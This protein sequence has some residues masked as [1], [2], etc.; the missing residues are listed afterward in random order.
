MT[1]NDVKPFGM[2][3]EN[4]NEQTASPEVEKSEEKK[5]FKKELNKKIFSQLRKKWA[6]WVAAVGV[7]VGGIALLNKDKGDENTNTPKESMTGKSFEMNGAE[8][9]LDALVGNTTTNSTTIIPEVV[10]PETMATNATTITPEVIHPE[11]IT[12]NVI[13]VMPDIAQSM[14]NVAPEV[15]ANMPDFDQRD[16]KDQQIERPSPRERY[17]SQRIEGPSLRERY[18]SQRIERPSPRE[19][20]SSLKDLRIEQANNPQ[21]N[22]ILVPIQE[23]TK[24]KYNERLERHNTFLNGANRNPVRSYFELTPQEQTDF[25]TTLRQ[26]VQSPRTR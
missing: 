15:N 24:E 11:T 9:N 26:L 21:V 17:L 10:Q 19:R 13:T 8:G 2:P 25:N 18:L 1:G 22:G 4:K 14:E 23:E 7:A 12:N 16:L 6:V 5:G 3:E 20:Y